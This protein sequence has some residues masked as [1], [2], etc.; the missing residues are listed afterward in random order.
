VNGYEKITQRKIDS[1][2]RA[3][4]E[5]FYKYGV[6]KVNM[7]EVANYANVSKVTIYKYYKSKDE[8]FKEVV[9]K[10][11]S[12]TFIEI[13]EIVNSKNN[14]TQKLKF[15]IYSK[16]KS[17]NI[18]KG[19]FIYEKFEK[20]KINLM[21]KLLEEGKKEN[22]IRNDITIQD[23][24]MYIEIFQSGLNS[25]IEYIENI[26]KDKQTVIEKM[27]DFFLWNN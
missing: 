9:K 14:F 3:A 5:L 13:E 23:F 26:S 19:V 25:K 6:S 16:V 7:D 12:K 20:R 22:Y 2:L 18:A 8:L 24:N 17:A 27:I 11:Y 15:I 10:I 1:I 4:T 21:N